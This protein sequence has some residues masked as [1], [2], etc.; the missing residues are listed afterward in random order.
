MGAAGFLL[1]YK[2]QSN[3]HFFYV[4]ICSLH[5]FSILAYLNGFIQVYYSDSVRN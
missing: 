4:C 1:T 2:E 5:H 3:T